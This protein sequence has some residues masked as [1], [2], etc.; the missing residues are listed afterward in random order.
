[1][2]L[3][4]LRAPQE[5]GYIC[6]EC[7]SVYPN[8][9]QYRTCPVHGDPLPFRANVIPTLSVEQAERRTEAAEKHREFERHYQKTRGHHPA[10]PLKI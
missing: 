7:D 4:K 8:R 3:D 5:G 10:A 2:R 1:M 6:E 9:E